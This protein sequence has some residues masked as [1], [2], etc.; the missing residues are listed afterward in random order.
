MS[1]GMPRDAT[2]MEPQQIALIA[3]QDRVAWFCG[4]LLRI[5]ANKKGFQ[6]AVYAIDSIDTT[7]FL[8]TISLILNAFHGVDP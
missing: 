2:T 7:R 5:L 1:F 6:L 4:F 8:G 3:P